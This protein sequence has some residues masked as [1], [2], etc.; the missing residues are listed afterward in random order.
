MSNIYIGV[1]G[2]FKDFFEEG[3]V[4]FEGEFVGRVDGLMSEIHYFY[5]WINQFYC[6]EDFWWELATLMVSLPLLGRICKRLLMI[7]AAAAISIV[8]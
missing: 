3:Y 7:T 4:V 8:R 6:R 5:C 1:F 2:A